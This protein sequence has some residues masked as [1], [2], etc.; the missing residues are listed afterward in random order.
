MDGIEKIQHVDRNTTVF[1]VCIRHFKDDDVCLRGEEIF[2][3]N[4]AIPTI[5]KKDLSLPDNMD[6]AKKNETEENETEKLRKRIQELEK[7]IS[8]LKIHHDV[9]LQHEKIKSKNA[10]QSGVNRLNVVQKELAKKDSQLVKMKEISVVDTEMYEIIDCLINGIKPGEKYLPNVRAFCIS[11]HG[12]CPK[13]YNFV[14]NKFGKNIPHP[15]TIRE[16]YRQSNLDA[17]SG[18]S[19][20]S[21]EALRKMAKKMQEENRQLIVSLIMDEMAI[22]RNMTWCSVEAQINSSASLIVAH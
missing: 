18:I 5:F 13:A 8:K 11:L 7:D 15:E 2:L 4:I 10:I 21:M 16:W 20:S 22:Q 3:K 17:S 1:N 19:K 6:D 12:T 9:Q 14:R